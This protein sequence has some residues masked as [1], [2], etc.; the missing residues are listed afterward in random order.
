VKRVVVE[1]WYSDLNELV[2]QEFRREQGLR[3][4]TGFERRGEAMTTCEDF[5]PNPNKFSCK[6]CPY[7]PKELGGTGHCSV[8]V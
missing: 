3:F 5:Q 6:W 7:K 2:S 1:L 8:G 4:A